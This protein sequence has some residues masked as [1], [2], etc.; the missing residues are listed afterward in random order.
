[1]ISEK[2]NTCRPCLS[3]G[4]NQLYMLKGSGHRS[5]R[6]HNL[7]MSVEISQLLTKSKVLV[8]DKQLIRR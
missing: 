8:L 1:M 6:L 7:C 2:R 5:F 3:I 4:F